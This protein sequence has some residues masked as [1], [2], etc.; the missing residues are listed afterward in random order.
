MVVGIGTTLHKVECGGKPMY[1]PCL[2][3]HLPSVEIRLFSPQ[4][5]HTLYEG[6]STVFGNR[7]VMMI[8][9]LSIDI[10]INA[11][12]GNA[13]MLHDTLCSASEVKEIGP[14]IRSAL[15]HYERKVDMMDSSVSSNFA[16]WGIDNEVSDF[17]HHFGLQSRDISLQ[18]NKNLS[19]SQKELMLWHFKLGASISHI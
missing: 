8:D 15:P 4:T 3:Y 11:E 16:S 2:S 18:A 6:H 10:Q 1:L 7:V 12:A 9:H 14:L 5:Y 19:G 13:P 17:A